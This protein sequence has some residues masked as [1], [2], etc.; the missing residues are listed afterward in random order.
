METWTG[1]EKKMMRRGILSD[2]KISRRTPHQQ[3][4]LLSVFLP[5]S[6]FTIRLLRYS[7]FLSLGQCFHQFY[8][9]PATKK[10]I[11][12]SCLA[13][14]VWRERRW[15]N[16][17]IPDDY[18]TTST[19]HRLIS[20]YDYIPDKRHTTQTKSVSHELPNYSSLAANIYHCYVRHMS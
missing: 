4:T 3:C 12:W 11:W 10:L 7:R 19:V 2:W 16:A 18:F 1:G 5:F 6:H 20:H 13:S 14:L 17:S 9:S 8:S 15:H